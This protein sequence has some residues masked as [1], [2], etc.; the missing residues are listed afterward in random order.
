MIWLKYWQKRKEHKWKAAPESGIPADAMFETALSFAEGTQH[1]Y[2]GPLYIDID[3]KPTEGESAEEEEKR[4]AAAL[5]ETSNIINYLIAEYNYNFEQLRTYFTGSAGFHIEIPAGSFGGV[6]D[7]NLPL[8]YRKMVYRMFGDGK[9][10]FPFIDRRVYSTGKGRMWRRCNIKRSNGRYKIEVRP[11]RILHKNAAWFI[12]QSKKPQEPIEHDDYDIKL[13]DTLLNLFWEIK[14]DYD[15]KGIIDSGS[16]VVPSTPPEGKIQP[17]IECILEVKPGERI[18]NKNFNE[19]SLILAT[20]FFNA[21]I[22][23]GK[24]DLF[25]KNY[26]SASYPTKAARTKEY[27]KKYDYVKRNNIPWSCAYARA[28]GRCGE[29]SDAPAPPPPTVTTGPAP[30]GLES[31]IWIDTPEWIN[32]VTEAKIQQR[33]LGEAEPIGYEELK[34]AFLKWFPHFDF[35]MLQVI[36]ATLICNRM[37]SDPVWMLLQAPPSGGKTVFITSL[38]LI[39]QTFEI[40]MLTDKTLFSS[41][42][43][44]GRRRLKGSA[45]LIQKLNKK[46]LVFKDFTSIISKD[47]FSKPTLLAQFREVYDGKYDS[48]TGTGDYIHWEGKVGLLAGVTSAIEREVLLSDQLGERFLI[49]RKERRK[50]DDADAFYKQIGHERERNEE[51]QEAMYRYMKGADPPPLDDIT[52]SQD[53]RARVSLLALLLARGRVQINRDYTSPRREIISIPEPEEPYRIEKQLTLIG[54]ALA[55]ING[56]TKVDENDFVILGKIAI[57]SIPSVRMTI[58]RVLWGTPSVAMTRHELGREAGLSWHSIERRVEE[59]CLPTVGLIDVKLAIDEAVTEDDFGD[60]YRTQYTKPSTRK[61]TYFYSLS[62]TAKTYLTNLGD[63]LE[64]Y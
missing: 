19:L 24:A 15:M 64:H 40:S 8:I 37:D 9:D 47:R 43:G 34:E 11:G 13:N 12:E 49:Y 51:L 63:T 36:L 4:I 53:L 6:A 58:L 54:K 59:L 21:K 28:L 2:A 18:S 23:A 26:Q 1:L 56:R 25:L 7:N 39:Q 42:R 32:A 57:S 20:Y 5:Q 22:P 52:M 16:A 10:A 41:F 50:A 17:C 44:T 29:C 61:G 46:V 48:G 33:G 14:T 55:V 31:H 62:E 27:T 3:V 30:T 35:D 60:E 45:A 38:A